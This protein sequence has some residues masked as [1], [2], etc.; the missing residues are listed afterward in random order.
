MQ[1]GQSS[2]WCYANN[3]ILW[4]GTVWNDRVLRNESGPGD[5]LRGSN[6]ILKTWGDNEEAKYMSDNQFHVLN[7]S[8]CSVEANLFTKGHTYLDDK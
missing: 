3:Q 6:S 1:G 7:M 5:V 8:L 4:H 2:R